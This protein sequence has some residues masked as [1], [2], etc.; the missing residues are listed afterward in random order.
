MFVFEGCK[1]ELFGSSA[2]QLGIVGCDVDLN[3]D[4]TETEQLLFVDSSVS[5]SFL[6]ISLP[7][8]KTLYS[9][10]KNIQSFVVIINNVLAKWLDESYR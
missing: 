10:V 3:L 2:N 9:C 6:V 5:C 4:V 7:L 8:N 1:V